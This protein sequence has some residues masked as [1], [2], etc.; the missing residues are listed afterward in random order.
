MA[1]GSGSVT[2]L[3]GDVGKTAAYVVSK[4]QELGLSKNQAIGVA[5]NLK[6]ESTFNA[7]AVGDSGHAYGIAQ[8]HEDRQANFQQFTGRSIQGSSLDQQLA[9]VVHELTKG[10]E[11]GAG[12]KLEATSTA[13][14]AAAIISRYYER[15][16]AKVQEMTERAGIANQLAN[17]LG[18]SIPSFRDM[19]VLAAKTTDSV[20]ATVPALAAAKNVVVDY[21]GQ[22]E[23]TRATVSD[24]GNLI[25]TKMGIAAGALVK[26]AKD[27]TAEV[28]LTGEAYRRRELEALQYN[29]I[30]VAGNRTLADSVMET[31]QQ[32]NYTAELQKL[33]SDLDGQRQNAAEKYS[34]E[35]E[36]QNLSQAQQADLLSKFVKNEQEK[37]TIELEKQLRQATLT[38]EQYK[39]WEISLSGVGDQFAAQAAASE[40]QIS[41]YKDM[42][43]GLSNALMDAANSGFKSFKGLA[44]WLKQTFNNMILKPI[45]QAVAGG[46]MG[47]I[48]PGMAG[49]STPGTGS[50]ASLSS[51]ISGNSIGSSIS[52]AA[53]SMGGLGG[54]FSGAGSYSNMSYGVA[55]LGGA[56]VGNLFGAG[57]STGGA[58][59]STIGMAIAG[60]IGA[61]AGSI[62]GGLAGSL[63][64]NDN[65]PRAKFVSSQQRADQLDHWYQQ[66]SVKTSVFGTFGFAAH[67]T[68]DLGTE[69]D[70]QLATLTDKMAQVDNAIAKFMPSSEV[71]RVKGVLAGYEH[72]GTDFAGI[73]KERLKIIATGFSSTMQG[74][75]DFSKD[76]DGIIAQ[77]DN[78]IAI[79]QQAIPIFR[80]L[81]LHIGDT[82]DAALAAA[83]GMATA[84]GGLSNL[85]AMTDKYYQAFFT[86]EEQKD[87]ATKIAAG[88][89]SEWNATLGSVDVL[90][91]V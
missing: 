81:G 86:A 79:Q 53:S 73:F 65:S 5:A 52:G 3:T 91:A 89:L 9:F 22:F 10:T 11:K 59:G 32:A 36:K 56:L 77:I 19:S 41:V 82:A 67:G 83:A 76:A 1:A 6:K 72:T 18:A 40:K 51:L 2:K 29:Q 68:H 39:A 37:V 90:R 21:N 75:I 4:L 34:T 42:K 47:A 28:E 30:V 26:T 38:D 63:F 55:G 14:E 88:K 62:L 85:T 12:S 31:E 33:Q 46:I 60:P 74:L 78:L 7:G 57:G 48:M 20:T 13:A 54:I 71:D 66:Q 87:I 64:S 45:I 25:D 70:S 80:S 17:Q 58:I 15:P 61:A 8:W 50:L 69:V 23:Q 43:E 16:A 84:A 44:D 24:V 35:L 49:A 27:H